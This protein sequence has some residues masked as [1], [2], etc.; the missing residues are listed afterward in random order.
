MGAEV[1]AWESTA[2]EVVTRHGGELFKLTGDGGCVAFESARAGVDAATELQRLRG[3]SVTSARVA[4]FSG[5]RRVATA[6]GT[7][8]R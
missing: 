6:I 2:R 5:R 1:A 4:L 3:G 7:A 8:C